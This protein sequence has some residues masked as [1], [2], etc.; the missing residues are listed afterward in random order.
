MNK[1][2]IKLTETEFNTLIKESVRTIINEAF[3]DLVQ[4]NHFDNDKELNGEN[5]YYKAFVVLDGT[6]AIIANFDNYN[7]AVKYAKEL[8]SKHRSSTF[9]VY[10]VDDDDTY[11]VDE[12][13]STLVYSSDEDFA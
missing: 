11:S 6:Q 4:W 8:A 5:E 10:G 3:S 1:K 12:E 9:Y 7:D 13:D 2:T